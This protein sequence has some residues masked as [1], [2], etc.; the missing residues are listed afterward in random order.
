[1]KRV[2]LKCGRTT[3][4]GDLFCQETYCP[5]EMSPIVLSYGEW[6]G[7]IEIVKPI[8]VTRSA[9][10]YEAVHQ[11]QTVYLKV[12]HPGPEHKERLKREALFL[13]AIQLNKIKCEHLPTLLPPYA[14]TTIAQDA[15]GKTM[16]GD[17]LLYFFM[18]EHFEGQPLR[19]LLLENP[20]LWINH[21]GWLSIEL[22]SA[23]NCLH[24]QGL[25]HYGLSPEGI[26]VRIDEEPSVPRT[27]LYDFGIISDQQSLRSNWYDDFVLPAYMA[28]ELLDGRVLRADYRTDVYGLGMIL[29]E[30]LEGQPPYPFKLKGDAEVLDAIRK[31]NPVRMNRTED[32][33]K[34]AMLT[35]KAVHRHPERRFPTAADFAEALIRYFGHPPPPKKGR[36][37]SARTLVWV[38][39][40][41]LAIAFLIAVALSLTQF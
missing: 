17:Q 36:W 2:C 30:M 12:A 18:F 39:I 23:V 16:L 29:Y 1:M 20:Q 19:D 32:V 37:P 6:F 8:I 3:L 41:L 31:D 25:Y 21:V 28:P 22:A 5:A 4:G 11:K 35:M 15:Y 13:Q 34:I 7:D 24:L 14:F 33:S 26:L 9:V 38:A 40:A 10:L 27:L